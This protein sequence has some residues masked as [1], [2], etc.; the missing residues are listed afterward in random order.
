METSELI[1][2]EQFFTTDKLISEALKTL[3]ESRFVQNGPQE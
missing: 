2:T 1:D 3:F